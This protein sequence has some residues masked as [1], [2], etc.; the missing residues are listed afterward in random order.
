MLV[1]LFN[2]VA[3]LQA[4][5]FIKKEAP[6]FPAKSTKSLRTPVWKNICKRLLL[7]G[8]LK[9]FNSIFVLFIKDYIFLAVLLVEGFV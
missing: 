7:K 2:R 4:C 1:S 5:N 3:G 8:L 9:S 6:A